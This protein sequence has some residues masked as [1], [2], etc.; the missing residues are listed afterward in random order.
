MVLDHYVIYFEGPGSL[1][2]ASLEGPQIF[3]M[4]RLQAHP[5]KP[6]WGTWRF[7]DLPAP[8]KYD[9]NNLMDPILPILSV[10][11]FGPLFWALW[12]VQVVTTSNCLELRSSI[13]TASQGED[14]ASKSSY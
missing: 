4:E 5:S 1:Q 11:G 13:H 10:L 12:E 7:W 8:P 6:S 14:K 9:Q 3:K 2:E